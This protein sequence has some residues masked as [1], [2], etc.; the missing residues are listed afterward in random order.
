M[1][2]NDSLKV[3]HIVG[4][5]QNA[6]DTCSDKAKEHATPE[7]RMAF[8]VTYYEGKLQRVQE[9]LKDLLENG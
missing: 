5:I 9:Q 2:L 4:Q 3:S 8:A 7:L 1:D 6:L